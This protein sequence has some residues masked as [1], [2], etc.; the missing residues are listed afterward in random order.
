MMLGGNIPGK[1]RV[2]SI[3]LYDRRT[4]ILLTGDT[5]YPGR[6]YV[7]DGPAFTASVQRLVAFTRDKP[8]AHCR[9]DGYTVSAKPGETPGPGRA[10]WRAPGDT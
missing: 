5:L 8:V 3:A 2:A 10:G 1:T 6:L 9:I 7:R 4:A